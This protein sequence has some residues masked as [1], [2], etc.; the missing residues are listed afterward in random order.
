[1]L[2]L[3]TLIAELGGAIDHVTVTMD[4]HQDLDISHPAWWVDADGNYPKPFTLFGSQEVLAGDW[5]PSNPATYD[6]SLSYLVSLERASRYPH[7]IWPNHCLQGTRGHAVY[8]VLIDVLRSW[9]IKNQKRIQYV[10]KGENA[11]TEHFSGIKAEV[12]D[13]NDPHT[14][15]NQALVD[16]LEAA[17]TLLVGGEALSHCV[18]STVEDLANAYRDPASIEKMVLLRDTT[19]LVPDPPGA[20][21]LFSNKTE[22][23][24]EAM[25]ARGMRIMTT[26]EFLCD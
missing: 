1:M 22:A 7:T 6:R 5:T 12:V 24:L 9:S 10:S 15:L 2:R 18:M 8:S 17:D 3:A 4:T 14:Q 26:R 11:F 23:F 13:D 20:E 16:Q 21:G 19:S 25:R